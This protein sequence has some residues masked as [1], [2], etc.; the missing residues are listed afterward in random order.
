MG[1]GCTVSSSDVLV[2]RHR[3]KPL[4][5]HYGLNTCAPTQT[6]HATTADTDE[7]KWPIVRNRRKLLVSITE[8]LPYRYQ[9]SQEPAHI[10]S[11]TAQYC[12]S[13]LV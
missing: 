2:V 9:F 12:N 1:A 7:H 4:V 13:A 3:V 10:A 11:T 8:R 5:M 6:A